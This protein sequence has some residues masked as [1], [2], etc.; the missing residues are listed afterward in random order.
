M[1]EVWTR[2]VRSFEFGNPT[3]VLKAISKVWSHLPHLP[4][5]TKLYHIAS[6]ISR[7]SSRVPNVVGHEEVIL[8]KYKGYWF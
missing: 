7:D 1:T 8:K 2:R 5:T 4:I 3:V 6:R